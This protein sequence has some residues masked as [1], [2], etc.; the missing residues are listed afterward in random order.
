MFHIAAI[1]LSYL[2]AFLRSRHN[3]GLEVLA[4]RQHVAVV[5][6]RG[7]R[8]WTL[9]KYT[10]AVRSLSALSITV[11]ERSPAFIREQKVIFG[12][13]SSLR[14]FHCLEWRVGR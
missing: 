7:P 14:A 6:R 12:D 5:K 2:G 10:T 8:G 1:F 4:M 9:A 13:L 11:F 3:L